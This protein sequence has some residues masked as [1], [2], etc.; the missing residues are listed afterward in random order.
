MKHIR[1]LITV[2]VPCH[3][4]SPN[5]ETFYASISEVVGKDVEH[6]Y[7]LLYVNDGSRD[8]TLRKLET[9][10]HDDARVRILTLSRNFGKEI[11]ITAGMHYANGD[12][13]IMI[14][15]DGQHPVELM[16]QFI[17]KWE[18]GA[19]VVVGIRESNQ[20]EGWVKRYGSKLFYRLFNKLAG[21]QLIPGSSDFRLIDKAVQ[22]EFVRMT[23]RNRISRGLIDWLGFKQE[24]VHFHANARTAG[25]A[26]YSL[27]KLFSLALNSFVSLSPKPLYFSFYLGLVVLP[28]ALLLGLF[29]V[30]EMLVGDPMGLHIT[31]TAYLVILALFLLSIL[32]ISQGIAALYVSHIHTETQNRPLFIVD[33]LSSVNI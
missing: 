29:S 12:A 28:L 1:K 27:S 31:G 3:N 11:A 4:E 18:R 21:T 6:D 16:S 26:T 20:K 8:D 25:E 5:I 17:E 33:E 2:V 32:L 22:R 19:Q 15:A 13:T 24:Y 9:L 23:E 10:A 7:E 14:D 30:V